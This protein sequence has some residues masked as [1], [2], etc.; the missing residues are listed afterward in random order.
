LYLRAYPLDLLNLAVS[1]GLIVAP[2]ILVARMF[3][4]DPLFESQVAVGLILWYWLSTLFWEVGHGA[5][6]E[7]EEGILESLLATPASLLSLLAAKAV[8]TLLLNVYITAGIVG[9]FHMFGVRLAWPW[10]RFLAIAF[11]CGFA[12]SGFLLA[13]AGVVL[14]V[15]RAEN[16]GSSLQTI[17]G[18]LAGMTVDPRL[19]PKGVWVLS[20]MIPLTYGIEA[21]RR[22]LRGE[23]VGEQLVWLVILGGAYGLAG[24][25]LLQRAER[26][27]KASGTT[28]EF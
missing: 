27:M 10:P 5:R 13:Y 8:A 11:L 2:Y 3:G 24:W 1:P 12:L 18:A 14:L 23:M 16:L 25:A 21:A 15:K 4:V 22:L 6:E 7:M 19:F 26:R 20:Q 9:W 17:L 28:G